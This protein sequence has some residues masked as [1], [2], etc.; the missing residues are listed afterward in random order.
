MQKT[1]LCFLFLTF[2]SLAMS[3][4]LP[5]RTIPEAPATYTA[6][7]VAA[8]LIDGLGYR[9]YWASEGLSEAEIQ[10]SATAESRTIADTYQ[11]I[12][13]LSN[14]ILRTVAKEPIEKI[15]YG[16][17]SLD[18]M[19]TLILRNLEAASRLLKGSSPDELTQMEVVFKRG[20]SESRFPFWNLINGQIEDA[21]WH[22]GQVV[23]LRRMAGNPINPKVNVFLGK[24]NE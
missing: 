17:Q 18:E 23:M 2:S 21:V 3:Q 22:T 8:R 15:M 16:E 5:F 24:T 1:T 19:R 13:D 7:T 9:F 11:H 6:T 4:E 10:K 14:G 20:D 12:R